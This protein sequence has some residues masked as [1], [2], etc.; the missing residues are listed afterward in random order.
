MKEM[1]EWLI[2]PE[3]DRLAHWGLA[4]S[5]RPGVCWHKS[6]WLSRAVPH[7]GVS[8]ERRW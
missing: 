5:G 4:R 1:G 2:E 8:G 6:V 3:K 7:G